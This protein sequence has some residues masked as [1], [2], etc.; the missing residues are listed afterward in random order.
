MAFDEA[1]LLDA[2]ESGRAHLRFYRWSEPT[3]SLGYFQ[4]AEERLADPSLAE[5]PAVRRLSGGGAILHDDEWTYSCVVP[6]GHRFSKRPL[7]LY[8]V[9]HAAFVEVLRKLGFE[10]A[11]RGEAAA[12][13]ASPFLCFGRGDERDLVSGGHKVLGSA[14]RRRKGAVLQHGSLLLRASRFAPDYPGLLDLHGSADQSISVTFPEDVAGIVLSEMG[15]AEESTGAS[16]VDG[17]ARDLEARKYR[18]LSW[19]KRFEAE[20]R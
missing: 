3:L 11:A 9:V 1:L 5:L 14:Q 7:D 8:D 2:L 10:V 13:G 12:H 15:D 4:S 19:T 6:A 20:T 18:L 16:D 17:V